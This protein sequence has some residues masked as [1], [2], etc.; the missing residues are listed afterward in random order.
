MRVFVSNFL[1]ALIWMFL[2][3]DISFSQF[4]SGFVLSY[5]VLFIFRGLLPDSTYFR[6]SIGLIKFVGMFF[7]KNIKSNFIVAWEVLSPTNHMNPGFIRINPQAET[8]I[9]ITWLA[10][11]IS[12]IPG[13]LTVDTSEDDNYL[14]IHA[15]HISDPDEIRQEILDDIEPIILE[16]LE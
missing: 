1:L 12:L 14:Y 4:F 9:Q 15:M 2:W 6:R 7:Y 8:P 5:L 3:E 10:A 16:I 13:T 11:T